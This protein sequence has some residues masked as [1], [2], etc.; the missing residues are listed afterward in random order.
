MREG[1]KLLDLLA[2]VLLVLAGLL[3]FS[4]LY[5]GLSDGTIGAA[6]AAIFIGVGLLWLYRVLLR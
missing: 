1:V 6:G 3:E 5:W 2:G 4:S